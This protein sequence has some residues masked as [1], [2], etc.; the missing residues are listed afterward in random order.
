[1]QNP[2]QKIKDPRKREQVTSLCRGLQILHREL[3]RKEMN[4]RIQA[5]NLPLSI[6]LF[7]T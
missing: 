4:E 6:H 2:I 5:L 3:T 7:I 1:M